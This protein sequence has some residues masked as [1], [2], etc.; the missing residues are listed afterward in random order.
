ME[1]FLRCPPAVQ[2]QATM[3]QPD[4]V[5][6]EQQG[7]AL[8]ERLAEALGLDSDA[9]AAGQRNGETACPLSRPL[10]GGNL[11]V[12]THCFLLFFP[13]NQMMHVCL[14]RTSN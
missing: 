2:Q 5:R 7:N 13:Y 6:F 10:V 1:E 11:H 8:K 3:F 4:S 12:L 9:E 14:Q